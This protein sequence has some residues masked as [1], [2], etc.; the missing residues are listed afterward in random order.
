LF[1]VEIQIR[2]T[3]KNCSQPVKRRFLDYLSTRTTVC[4]NCGVK[5][6]HFARGQTGRGESVN[7]SELGDK[8]DRLEG[9]WGALVNEYLYH[10]TDR[11][12]DDDPSLGEA[13][14]REE[15]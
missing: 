4:P 1:S 6:V 7:L 3:C 12:T 8:I 10:Q 5:M 9:D 15:P 11:W 2:F 14:R 13:S